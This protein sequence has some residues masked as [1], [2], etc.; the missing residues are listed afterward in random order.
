M[1]QGKTD[2]PGRINRKGKLKRRRAV[3][4]GFE[5]F[6][7]ILEHSACSAYKRNIQT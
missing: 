1:P 4:V 7:S 6:I 2:S 3:L 5:K